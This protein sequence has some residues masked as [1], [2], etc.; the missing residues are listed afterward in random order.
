MIAINRNNYPNCKNN[1]KRNILSISKIKMSL[2]QLFL[3]SMTFI[4]LMTVSNNQLISQNFNVYQIDKSEF[5]KMKAFYTAKDAFYN[6]LTGLTTADFEIKE[7]GKNVTFEHKCDLLNVKPAVSISMMLDESTSMLILPTTGL[8]KNHQI[9]LAGAKVFLDSM[10]FVNGSAFQLVKFAG[11]IIKSFEWTES[12]AEALNNVNTYTAGRAGATNLNR[13]FWETGLGSLDRL[14]ERSNN[15]KKVAIMLTDGGHEASGNFL[16]NEI[17][18]KA[19]DNNIEIYVILLNAPTNIG[20]D[21]DLITRETGGEILRVNSKDELNFAF[22]KIYNK[23]QNIFTCRLEWTEPYVC[24]TDNILDLDRNLEITFKQTTPNIKQN[25]K[26]TLPETAISKIGISE[27]TLYF[28]DNNAGLISKDV[29][30]TALQGDYKLIDFSFLPSTTNFNV[31]W[32]GKSPKLTGGL[33]LKQGQTHTFTVNYVEKGAIGESNYQLLIKDE[34]C[35]V[36]PIDLIA[37]CGGLTENKTYTNLP[38]AK[39]NLLL[40]D[41]FYNNSDRDVA[42]EILIMNDANS[43]LKLLNGN[44]FTINSKQK[45]SLN[46]EFN[47][48]DNNN[49]S[50]DI[51]FKTSSGCSE[52]I[53]KLVIS[54][55]NISVI[56][57]PLNFGNKRVNTEA[58]GK[59]VIEN[60]SDF[61]IIVN[62]YQIDENIFIIED[63]KTNPISL[64]PKSSKTVNVDFISQ[65]E[66]DYIGIIEF[67]YLVVENNNEKN[68]IETQITAN[69]FLPTLET[70]DIIFPTTDINVK[71]TNQILSITNNSKNGELTITE[72]RFKNGTNSGDFKFVGTPKLTNITVA[73]NSTTQFELEFLPTKNGIQN[74]ILEILADNVKGPEPITNIITEVKLTGNTLTLDAIT[75]ADINFG[76]T[77][78]CDVPSRTIEIDNSNGNSDITFKVTK[79]N[80][81]NNFQINIT[82]NSIVNNSIGGFD[83]L[84]TPQTKGFHTEDIKVVLSDGREGEFTISG[85]ATIMPFKTT[86]V[87]KNKSIFP[88]DDVEFTF[89]SD[90]NSPSFGDIAKINYIFEYDKNLFKFI[91]NGFK[92]SLN[93]I[94]N[95]WSWTIDKIEEN[96]GKLYISGVKINGYLTLPTK[97]TNVIKF[98]SYLGD[99]ILSSI[100]IITEFENN[101]ITAESD[102]S[103]IIMVGC[104]ISGRLI[105]L[106]KEFYSKGLAPN[107]V[108]DNT[109]FEYGVGFETN[110]KIDMYDIN[111]TLVYN[112]IE[113]RQKAGDYKINIPVIN[114]NQGVYFIKVNAG[115]YEETVKFILNK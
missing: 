96:N 77:F 83:V 78:L 94:G 45:L 8:E 56:A 7:D 65:V 41:V 26:Y 36:P 10:K 24:Q 98:K 46:L 108:V 12:K 9:A 35:A 1:Y 80:N 103:Q 43:E 30:I 2:L 21:L 62:D 38:Q 44:K 100:K 3:A 19:Q 76:S 39:Q 49:K 88:G 22:F 91:E 69:T 67:D 102:T 68:S 4:T 89:V 90:F 110:V 15:S 113:A 99:S 85:N 13:P 63:I 84:F 75:F 58:N 64:A 23:L 61:N 6:N 104:F 72:I 60:K 32:K 54:I 97:V 73:K 25:I 114:L 47:P 95:D 29:T 37:P 20:S 115:P 86:F 112:L 87:E 31:D 57:N 51:K 27:S 111:G 16:R 107:P 66:Q 48:I 70:Q 11:V 52:P 79:V 101:C 93:N 82:N 74:S 50:F 59:I 42:L 109:D 106:G 40:K 34:K 55:G 17:I 71:S 14:I 18:K 53:A 33:V 5:P 81:S 92:S 105:T 28:S